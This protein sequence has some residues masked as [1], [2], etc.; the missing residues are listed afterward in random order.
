MKGK[1]ERSSGV[2]SQNVQGVQGNEISSF[3]LMQN[4]N[5]YNNTSAVSYETWLSGVTSGLATAISL[6]VTQMLYSLQ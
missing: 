5:S 2:L 3:R 6:A 1:T 4:A